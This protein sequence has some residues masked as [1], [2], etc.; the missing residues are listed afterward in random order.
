MRDLE[1]NFTGNM[2]DDLNVKKAF[3]GICNVVSEIKT[4]DLNPAEAAGVIT[5]LRKIDEVFKVIF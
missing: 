1:K 2:D 4:D 5:I 3:D